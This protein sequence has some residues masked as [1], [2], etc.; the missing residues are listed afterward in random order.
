MNEALPDSWQMLRRLYDATGDQHNAATAAEHIAVLNE[1]P[2]PIIRA[3][4]MFSDGEWSAAESIVRAYLLRHGHHVEALRLLARIGIH[5]DVL[6]DAERLLESVLKLAP[7]YG[8]ARAD[9]AGVLNKRQ[10]YLQARREMDTLLQLEPGNR[11]YL[12]LYASACVGL[13]DYAPIIRLYRQMLAQGPATGAETADLHLWLAD[14][15]KTVGRQPEAIQEYHAAVAAWPDSG[16]AWWSLANLKTYHLS[17]DDIARMRSAE[18]APA[19][20]L[21]DRYHLCFAL[22]KALE[23][24]SEYADSWSYYERGNAL[25]HAEVRYLPGLA[26]A[27]V[28][29]S[30]QVCTREFFDTRRGWGVAD[31]D[32]I[33]ILGLT[34]SGSTLIEQILAS[35]SEVEGT[36]E[37]ADIQRIVM[38]LRGRDTDIQN[39]R[40]PGV[41]AELGP[42]DFRKFGERFMADTRIY[43]KTQRP[44][45]ID[46][47]PDNFRDIGLIRLMLP[48]AKII[49]ARRE[50]MACCFGNL[51]QLFSGGQEF[52][53]SIADIAHYY[54]NYLA[55]MRHWNEA[56][57]GWILTVQHE[58]VVENLEGSV[59]RVLDFCGLPF[60]PACLEFHKTERHVRTASSEQVRRPI[61]REGV[62][63]WRKYEPW[64][65][66]LKD[67]LGDALTTYRD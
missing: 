32:P 35:H 37:L 11:D 47:L 43:R 38:A 14:L 24:Q 21:V 54:R 1:L 42:Q 5:R 36:R 2:P 49:D 41:L 8:A 58:D 6:D 60:E 63:Q 55:L 22:G 59:R 19:T 65:G 12:K 44:F 52:S 16:E 27:H 40:Y 62:D 13:G 25:K 4:S 9:Y 64:L 28:R 26:E 66:P 46:K 15:L 48:N 51:K 67:G 20:S 34:R 23:D 30:K 61:S 39:P 53:Y 50:P 29:Q 56:L 17:I 7:D 57:P 10:K 31:A 18:A 33:F 3:G 45:F